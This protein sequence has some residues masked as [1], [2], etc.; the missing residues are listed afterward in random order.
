MKNIF[1]YV[2]FS[3]NKIIKPGEVCGKL[4]Q[5]AALET[6][7]TH[8][9]PVASALIDAHAGGLGVMGCKANNVS[10]DFT[11]RIGKLYR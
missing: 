3:G 1:H 6:G 9:T 5:K 2:I 10:S 11:T 8:G 7:L 4:S